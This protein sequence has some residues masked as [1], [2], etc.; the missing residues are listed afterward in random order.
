MRINLIEISQKAACLGKEGDWQMQEMDQIYQEYAQLVYR[1]LVSLC[2]DREWAKD[3]AQET[4]LRAVER[5][6]SYQ[7]NGNSKITTWLCQI[8]RYVWYQELA[9]RSKKQTVELT[10]E[11]AADR[12]KE[13]EELLLRRETRVELF[14]AVQALEE[15]ARSVV[16]LR[17]SGELTFGEIGEILGRSENW[18]RVTYYRSREKLAA[19]IRKE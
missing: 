12:D 19:R 16:H 4:F 5:I 6:D 1:Y 9:K 18:A 2:H 3:M 17:L 15:P 7:N 10:D 11:T 13:P 8:A 14:R